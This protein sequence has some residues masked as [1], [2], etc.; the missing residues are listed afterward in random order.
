MT[1]FTI[2]MVFHGMNQ[3]WASV[4]IRIRENGR[5]V[6]SKMTKTKTKK[7]V[8]TNSRVQIGYDLY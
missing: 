5:G 7:L 1:D 2:L 3:Y 4:Y 8:D 6:G